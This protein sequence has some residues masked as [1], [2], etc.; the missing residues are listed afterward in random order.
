[1]AR[2]TTGSW[3]PEPVIKKTSIGSGRAVKKS[4]MNKSKKASFKTYKGQ[5]K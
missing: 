3:R 4:S 2:S 1:M 5:G